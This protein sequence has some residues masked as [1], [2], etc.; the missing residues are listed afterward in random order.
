MPVKHKIFEEVTYTVTNNYRDS[1]NTCL[2]GYIKITYDQLVEAFGHP[3]GPC[4][5]GK[6]SAEWII[7]FSD[8]EVATIYDYKMGKTPK[9]EYEWHIGGLSKKVVARIANMLGVE[10]YYNS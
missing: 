7:R 1:K 9:D 2:Q 5:Y 10:N 8:A 3:L 4:G 6:I